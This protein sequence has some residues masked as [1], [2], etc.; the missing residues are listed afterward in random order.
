MG[1]VRS[2]AVAARALSLVTQSLSRQSRKTGQCC[3]YPDRHGKPSVSLDITTMR[4]A[5][6]AITKLV[7]DIIA[8]LQVRLR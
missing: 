6:I 5:Y 4:S 7:D 3:M 1:L 8:D 2:V